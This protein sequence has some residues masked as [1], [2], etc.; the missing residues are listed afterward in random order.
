[1]KLVFVLKM[2][3]Y[4]AIQNMD[5]VW[6]ALR[7]FNVKMQMKEDLSAVPLEDVFPAAMLRILAPIQRTSA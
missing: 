7:V 1:M 2:E 6:S 5:F 3:R 4:T